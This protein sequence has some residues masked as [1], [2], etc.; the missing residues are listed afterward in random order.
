M[1]WNY[2]LR[3]YEKQYCMIAIIAVVVKTMFNFLPR[4]P[5]SLNQLR[6]KGRGPQ[7]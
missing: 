6:K 5:S 4:S 3:M 2:F 1:I 7:P